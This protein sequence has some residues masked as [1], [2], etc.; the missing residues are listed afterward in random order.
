MKRLILL[1]SLAIALLN[2]DFFTKS[3]VRNNLS[4]I[5]F[6][7]PEYP[8]G[9]I[10]VFHDWQGI[11]FSINFATNTGAAWSLLAGYQELLVYLRIAIVV[12]IAVYLLFVKNSPFRQVAY[13]F[14]LVG[15][16]GNI[17]DHFLYGYVVDLFYFI[18]WGYSY[19]IFNVAD[20]AIF[21]GVALLLVQSFFRKNSLHAEAPKQPEE[22]GA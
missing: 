1:V 10:P 2:I 14:I 3:F 21:C 9:G 6:A 19:P 13:T 15:A 5:R 8:F 17:L 4:E 11:D 12:G 20:S 16:I 7:S 18:F 22:S